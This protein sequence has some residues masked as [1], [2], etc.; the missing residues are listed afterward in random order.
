MPNVSNQI[1]ENFVE[2]WNLTKTLSGNQR[3]IIFSS[4]SHKERKHLEKSYQAGGW[5]DL[6]MRNQLD[7][8]VD[9]L[10]EEDGYNLIDIHT[11]VLKGKSVY[12]PKAFWSKVL[13]KLQK[14]RLIDVDYILGGMAGVIC[15]KNPDV[16][17]LVRE[18]QA[19]QD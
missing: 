14:Q 12:V 19:A 17:L 5:H 16:L 11:K 8:L 1:F 9:A 7:E 2:Y 18:D 13:T 15:K 6:V 3:N 4:L 10:E